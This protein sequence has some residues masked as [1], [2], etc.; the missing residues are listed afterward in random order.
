LGLGMWV[1]K[2]RVAI[3]L[4]LTGVWKLSNS[5]WP[6]EQSWEN[7]GQKSC[8]F[9]ESYRIATTEDVFN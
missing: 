9:L 6:P 2:K 1:K 5:D 3:S 4:N 7:C 8:K